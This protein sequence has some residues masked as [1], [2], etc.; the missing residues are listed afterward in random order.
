M[1]WRSRYDQVAVGPNS[2]VVEP[3]DNTTSYRLCSAAVECDGAI[4]V[5]ERAAV[6]RPVSGDGERPGWCIDGPIGLCEA[7]VKCD[8]IRKTYRRI[9]CQVDRLIVSAGV[10]VDS[11]VKGSIPHRESECVAWGGVARTVATA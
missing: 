6:L 7:T 11:A 1:G 9:F 10:P 3:G 5:V 4:V 2:Q 8:A